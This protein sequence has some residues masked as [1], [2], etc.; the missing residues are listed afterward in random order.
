MGC[1]A[2]TLPP[3]LVESAG[4]GR[5][6]S[7][8][9]TG[10]AASDTSVARRDPL[11]SSAVAT[12]PPADLVLTPLKGDGPTVE[13]WLTVFHLLSVVVD[14]YTNESSWVLDVAARIMREFSGAAV[15]VN[16]IV[17][18]DPDDARAF[19]GPL[20]SEFLTFT[21]PDR[22]AVKALGLER[23]PAFV[24]ILMDGT[25]AASAE[26]WDPAEWR[27]VADTIATAV[28]WSRPV[29]PEPGDPQAFEGSPA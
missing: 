8:L 22:A 1:T 25:V 16:W 12:D 29:I 7:I 20:A 5:A 13:Q 15:R 4:I 17:A 28:K 6:P 21:D 3:L 19:L 24:F 27:K 14:P 26:G 23:L 10:R 11:P 9:L 2:R 18:A